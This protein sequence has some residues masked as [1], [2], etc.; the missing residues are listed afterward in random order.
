MSSKSLAVTTAVILMVFISCLTFYVAM[1]YI[2]PVAVAAAVVVA[3]IGM[4]WFKKS[5]T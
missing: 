3:A 4:A 2:N 1:Q 5:V